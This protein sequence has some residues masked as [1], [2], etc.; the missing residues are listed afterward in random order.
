MTED[1]LQYYYGE[2]KIK[3]TSQEHLTRMLYL[4]NF[5]TPK[6]INELKDEIDVLR[7]AVENLRE[8]TEVSSMGNSRVTCEKRQ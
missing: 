7:S 1:D 4:R 5:D 8:R 2:E 3:E 6:K